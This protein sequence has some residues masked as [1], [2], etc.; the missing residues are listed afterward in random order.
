MSLAQ[1]QVSLVKGHSFAELTKFAAAVIVLAPP[2]DG[3]AVTDINM[4]D[5]L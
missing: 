2:D 5:D 3:S 1:V 4:K